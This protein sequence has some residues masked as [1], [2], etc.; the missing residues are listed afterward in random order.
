MTDITLL[1]GL[2]QL[3]TLVEIARRMGSLRADVGHVQT[4]MQDV[5]ERVDA[6]E[7]R[8]T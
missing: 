7:Q 5:R 3:A 8:G 1:I 4:R 2:G 6:L